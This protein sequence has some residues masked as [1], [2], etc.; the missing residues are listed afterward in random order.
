MSIPKQRRCDAPTKLPK[1][2]KNAGQ[3]AAAMVVTW[4]YGSGA[5]LKYVKVPVAK[6]R[7]VKYTAVASYTQ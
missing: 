6:L 3:N 1:H 2:S 7:L 4:S 5:N